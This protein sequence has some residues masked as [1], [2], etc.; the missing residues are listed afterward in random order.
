N[1]KI[2]D[3]LTKELV[4]KFTA[5]DL[6]EGNRGWY[7]DDKGDQYYPFPAPAGSMVVQNYQTGQIVA[8]A[9]YPNFDNRWFTVGLTSKKF[10]VLFPATKDP[11][12]STLVNRAIQG[13][14][15]MGS[16]FKPVVALA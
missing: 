5:A 14:Y 11:D 10:E 2:T 7:Y 3:K 8:M 9:S 4:L 16:T 1:P 6:P 12:K 13:Q 15:N